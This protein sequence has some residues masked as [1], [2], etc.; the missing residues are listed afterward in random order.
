MV[1]GT[2]GELRR[3]FGAR[4]LRI[5]LADARPPGW[6]AR[7]P[8]VRVLSEEANWADCELLP[9]A[10]SQ[11]VLAAGADLGTVIHFGWHE[12]ALHEIFRE[13]VQ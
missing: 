9:G 6:A 7:L 11:E 2:V 4:R 8:G 12:S 3:R 1:G 10:S 5:G 13:V